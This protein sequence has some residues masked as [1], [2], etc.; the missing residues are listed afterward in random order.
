MR[1]H[2]LISAAIVGLPVVAHA[3]VDLAG[4]EA[5]VATALE[6]GGN[7]AACVEDAQ[8]NCL[9]TPSDAPAVGMLCYV[10]AEAAWQ[11]GLQGLMAGVQANAPEDIATIAA[12]ELKYDLLSGRLQ[13][14]RVEELSLAVGTEPEDV[15]QRQKARCT[16]TTAGLAYVRLSWRSQDYQ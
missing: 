11:E 14:D 5:C 8:S 10:E 6:A 9:L 16:A 4:V 15:I 7:P 1:I 2:T 13:C 3:D 12:I